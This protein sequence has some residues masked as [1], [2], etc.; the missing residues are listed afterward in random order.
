MMKYMLQRVLAMENKWAND[1]VPAIRNQTETGSLV[2]L[3]FRDAARHPLLSAPEE[4]RLVRKLARCYR[5]IAEELQLPEDT[6]HTFAETM[7]RVENDRPLSARGRRAMALAKACRSRLIERNLRLSVHIAKRYSKSDAPIIDLIQEGNVGLIRAVD[8]FD[9]SK[10]FRFSTYAH[11]WITQEVKECAQRG[12]RS[13]RLPENIRGDI[14]RYR[15]ATRSLT[16]DLGREPAA[17]EIAAFMDVDISRIHSLRAYQVSPT[18][19]DKSVITE[20]STTLG[21]NLQA[22]DNLTPEYQMLGRDMQRI[23][24]LFLNALTSR[25]REVLA[26]R[27]GINLP[28]EETLQIV[29]ERLGISRE[30]VRQIEK[31]AIK[32]LSTLCQG[33]DVCQDVLPHSTALETYH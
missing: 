30:R 22:N 1:D 13:V 23:V 15:Q 26:R 16:Q 5:L 10:G 9:P 4:R 32:K 2:N 28:S 25:E 8:R 29:S 14:R 6:P 12:I 19:I 21:D 27:F 7:G 11:W 31:S 24:K 3:Y 20:G 17:S 18:S 33:S